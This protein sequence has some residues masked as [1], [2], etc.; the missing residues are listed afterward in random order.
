MRRGCAGALAGA[1]LLGG[2]L[3]AWSHLR[4]PHLSSVPFAKLPAQEQARR[5]G[6]AQQLEGQVSSIEQASRAH[7]K[8]PFALEISDEQLNTLLQDRLDLSKFP[9]RNLRVGFEPGRVVA[10]GE[11]NYKGFPATG[12]LE[13]RVR[14]QS[15]R[16]IYQTDSLQVMGVPLPGNWKGQLDKQVSAQLNSALKRAPGRI[17]DVQIEQNKLVVSGHTD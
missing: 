9:I 16:L 11:V 13:G 7:E 8:K 1:L 2:G 5:R 4:G 15:G 17:E 12:T 14:L 6:D 3:W 10:Q